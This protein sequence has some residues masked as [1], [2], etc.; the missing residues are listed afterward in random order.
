MDALIAMVVHRPYVL[1][2]LAFFLVLS[3][4]EQ[5]P[6]RT[7]IWLATGTFLG[8][9]SE[10]SSVRTGIPFGLYVYHSENFPDELWAGGVPIFASLSFAF[11]SYFGYSA[12]CAFLGRIE[13]A[14][15][16]AVRR[17]DPVLERSLAV[18]ALAA[19]LTV[20]MDTVIDPV[21]LLGSHWFLGDLY[22]YVGGGAHLG[23]PLSNYGGWFVT[24]GAIVLANQLLHRA[25]DR[26]GIAAR[27]PFALPYGAYLGPLACGGVFAFV[28]SIGAGLAVTGRI[29]PEGQIGTVVGS[30]LA[31]TAA[32]V[33]FA[34]L[35]LRRARSQTEPEVAGEVSPA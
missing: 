28:L 15:R 1:V 13:G 5:G 14:G 18:T 17:A 29:P 32:Y 7:A 33:A 25:L 4:S 10:V 9:L 31:L 23:V 16:D 30:G 19:G 6:V 22:H 3:L 11:A 24:C 34:L 35:A 21:S 2:F 27:R 20:W 26:A 8:W 12:A